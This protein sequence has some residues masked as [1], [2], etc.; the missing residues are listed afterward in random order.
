MPKKLRMARTIVLIAM[1]CLSR[2]GAA[3]EEGAVSVQRS[4]DAARTY[5]E[6]RDY[7]SALS[8][9]MPALAA[10]PLYLPLW[11]LK[12]RILFDTAQHDLADEAAMVRLAADPND[13]ETAGLAFRN[14]LV[15][16]DLPEAERVSRLSALIELVGSETF[17]AAIAALTVNLDDFPGTAKWIVAAWGSTGVP[18]QEALR[19]LE[20]Y[21]KQDLAEAAKLLEDR[22]VEPALGAWVGPL[23]YLVGRAFA[24]T[25]DLDTAFA[26]LSRA[27]D[28]GFAQAETSELISMILRRRGRHR[29]AA[30][31]LLP[32]W[33]RTVEPGNTVSRMVDDFVEGGAGEQALALLDDAIPSFPNLPALQAKRL[34]VL[35]LLGRESERERYAESLDESGMLPGLGYGRALVARNGGREGEARDELDR[36]RDYVTGHLGYNMDLEVT[37]DWLEHGPRP[38]DLDRMNN[39]TAQ[40]PLGRRLWDEGR[41]SEAIAL[42][43]KSFSNAYPGSWAT[44]F[45]TV[46]M[47]ANENMGREAIALLSRHAPDTSPMDLVVT[48]AQ[49]NQWA[50]VKALFDAAEMADSADT[51]WPALFRALAAAYAGTPDETVEAVTTFSRYP[52]E[53]RAFSYRPPSQ[54]DTEAAAEMPLSEHARLRRELEELLILNDFAELY[55]VMLASPQWQD[56]GRSGKNVVAVFGAAMLT[57]GRYEQARELLGGVLENEPGNAA[58]NLYLALLEQRLG[59][60][61]A[62]RRRVDAGLERADGPERERLLAIRAQLRGDREQAIIHFEEYLRLSPEDHDVR[63][64]AIRELAAVHRYRDAWRL[65]RHFELLNQMVNEDVASY[66]ASA[67]GELGAYPEAERLWRWLVTRYPLSVPPLAGLGATLNQMEKPAAAVAALAQR[68]EATGNPELC[69]LMA[70]AHLALGQGGEGINWVDLGLVSRPDDLYLLGDGAYCAEAVQR[71]DLMEH[72]S[73]RYLALSPKSAPMSGVYGQALMDQE[74]WDDVYALDMKI[75][76][77]NCRNWAALERES[78]RVQAC[79]IR[80]SNKYA[81]EVDK[82]I[83]D[84][85]ANDPALIIRAAVTAAGAG[86]FRYAIPTLERLR[87]LGPNSSAVSLLFNRITLGEAVGGVPVEEVERHLVELSREH[88][89]GELAVLAGGANRDA[90]F[91]MPVPLV[92][93]IGRSRPDALEALDAYLAATGGHACLVVGEESLVE[94]TPLWADIACLRR[95]AETGRWEFILTDHEPARFPDR[96]DGQFTSFWT[97][98]KWLD[99]RYETPDEMERRLAKELRRLRDKAEAAGIPVGVWL[100]PSWGDYGHRLIAAE[101]AQVMAYRSAV[102]RVFAMALTQTPS[103]LSIAGGDPLRVPIRPI[104]PGLDPEE[105]AV[106]LMYQHPTRRAV[107]ELAKVKSWHSQFS[108]ANKLFCLAR[109]YGLDPRE[110]SY[111]QGRNSYY[112]GDV[113]SGADLSHEALAA[114]PERERAA[115]LFADAHRLFRPLLTIEPRHWVDT[116]DEKYYEVL[117]SVSFHVTKKW[118]LRANAGYHRWVD[119][120]GHS[121]NGKSLGVGA[122]YYFRPENYV[123]GEVRGVSPNAGG[124]TY[125]EA[126]ALWNGRFAN[127]ALRADGQFSLEYHREGIETYRA[128]DARIRANRFAVNTSTRVADWWDVDLDAYAIT[129][130]DGNDTWG[131]MFR[132]TYR[133]TEMPQFRFGY[134]FAAADSDRNPDEYYAPVEYFAISWWPCTGTISCPASPST[135]SAPTAGPGPKAPT[136]AMCSGPMP[137]SPTA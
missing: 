32:F 48:M 14:L 123:Q 30:E 88:H 133:F 37:E 107:L 28:I 99:G 130:T 8:T 11:S 115:D 102:Q 7:A 60:T 108:T 2:C 71:H 47:L 135:P 111:F 45:N 119:E 86:E 79:D 29:E 113:P 100:H 66:L 118:Q 17:A 68:A 117:A 58:A 109:T 93:V 25:D 61:G 10:D 110:I 98:A 36:V 90:D 52:S 19:I 94:K 57:A 83:A 95:L 27:R 64:A 16:P 40:V 91:I 126:H 50:G 92:T 20:L 51:S 49:R 6:R 105:L 131:M 34:L 120:D 121:M 112:E 85:F 125:L 56:V 70:E 73:A 81:W 54:D 80:K 5:Y 38:L 72:Y 69:A 122:R 74:K 13:P 101:Q 12:A 59:H 103:G 44:L 9:L 134:W 3:G 116:N 124:K 77:Q 63:L 35:H 75:L 78:A 97:E 104:G 43:D 89:F 4:L 55:P 22:R 1:L 31:A 21:F 46:I 96:V 65:T 87:K 53:T 41:R 26:R 129:R 23:D 18:P 114:D 33:R 62:A 137:A 67:Y 15:W 106:G 132:P 136:G 76:E 84:N 127:E 42:W 82:V 24:Y 128:Q 39:A